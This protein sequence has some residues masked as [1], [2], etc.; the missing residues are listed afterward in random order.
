MDFAFKIQDR[1]AAFPDITHVR[2][3]SVA[4]ICGPPQLLAHDIQFLS[5]SADNCNAGAKRH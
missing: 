4:P 2:A 5:V 1:E 3:A